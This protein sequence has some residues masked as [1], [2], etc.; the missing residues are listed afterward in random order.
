MNSE[1]KIGRRTGKTLSSK[2]EDRSISTESQVAS[3]QNASKLDPFSFDFDFDD[4]DC[5]CE[6]GL[7]KI[8]INWIA[9]HTYIQSKQPWII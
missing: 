7:H 4:C 2:S 8:K 3:N 5:K 9:P 1:A 6:D